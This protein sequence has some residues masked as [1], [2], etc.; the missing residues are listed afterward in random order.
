VAIRIDGEALRIELSVGDLVAPEEADPFAPARGVFARM[1]AGLEA[2]T[3]YARDA[4]GADPAYRREVVIRRTLPGDVGGFTAEVWGRM[5]GLY[6]APGG[7][8]VE[9]VKSVVLGDAAF[10]AIG[11]ES[12]PAYRL[13]LLVYLYLIGL[14]GDGDGGGES[15]AGPAPARGELV[16]VNLPGREVR[17]VAVELDRDQVGR[18]IADRIGEILAAWKGEAERLQRRRELAARLAFPFPARRPHQ[19]ELEDA[20][21]H[22]F[23]SGACLLASAP[24]GLGKTAAVLSAA[25][26]HAL[27]SDRRVYFVT[28]KTTEQR[29]VASTLQRL[30]AAHPEL[31][32]V[33]LRAKAKICTNDVVFCHPEFCEFARDYPA[34]VGGSRARERL[35][36]L[37]LALP[38]AVR[39][40][41]LRIRACPFEM[42]L[43]LTER[44]DVVVG[45]YN[46]VFDPLVSLR[47]QF[48]D[49]PS[50]DL[51]LVIDEAH[52]LLDRAREYY[53]PEL[54][55]ARL[56]QLGALVTLRPGE[57]YRAIEGW[58]ERL[59]ALFETLDR[60]RDDFER[61]R[62]PKGGED[63]TAF[64]APLLAEAIAARKGE[65]EAILLEY[66]VFR[67]E[68]GSIAPD[69]PVLAVAFDF[70]RF[71]RVA[72]LGGDEF[73]YLYQPRR[74]G[75]ARY[76]IVCL[77][78]SR[79]VG[80]RLRSFHAVVAMSATLSPEE[81]YRDLLGF[82]AKRTSARSFPS[83]FRRENRRVLVVPT[84]ATTWR[85]RGSWYDEVAATIARVVAAG[86]GHWIAFLP[87]FAYLREVHARLVLATGD[88][89]VQWERMDEA[90]RRAVLE[91]LERPDGR[92]RLLLAVLGG[93]FAEGIDLPGEAVVGVVVVS[94][95]LPQVSVDR[96]LLRRRSDAVHGRGFEYA[97]LVPGMNRVVQ[98]AGRLVRSETDRGVI[99][100]LDRRFAAPEYARLLPRDWY[101]SAP[102]ELHTRRP[103]R[104]VAEFFATGA[105]A[106]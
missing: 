91:R 12:Y 81:Y 1:A 48:E 45:D 98:A 103:E 21:R 2:H 33:V 65:L 71:A 6:K 88:V 51:V 100:L 104:E 15:L 99:I 76:R 59:L 77:D 53:S 68:S 101:D 19:Q 63:A 39:E 83:P 55:S 54:D 5:D 89:L 31:T 11:P 7:D 17:R 25:L 23:D 106:E 87:S 38:D 20:A 49:G 57:I 42:E 92:S 74:A 4:I 46:Y 40:E 66:F 61:L 90:E 9:E 75:T 69:D 29:I 73:V 36:E 60:G 56:A 95:G 86:P 27:A 102:R 8:V 47:R 94:P 13:Q 43:D 26:G 50:D 24:P 22:A 70:L 32:A 18:F 62:D 58:I 78:P 80:R 67:R 44:A 34:K 35:L 37:G 82:P 97:Y 30:T 84:V 52:N 72:D 85:E 14:G 41:A 79:Q 105:A 93:I 16:F 10:A 96:E 28:S 64:I 3:A